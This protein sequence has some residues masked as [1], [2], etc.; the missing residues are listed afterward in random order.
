MPFTNN[1]RKLSKNLLAKKMN[2]QTCNFV[3]AFFFGVFWFGCLTY[4][5]LVKSLI[6]VFTTEVLNQLTP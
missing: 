6:S 3:H 5:S 4:G 1:T 2:E